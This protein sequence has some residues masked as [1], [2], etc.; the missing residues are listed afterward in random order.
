MSEKLRFS[1]LMFL[2]F[3]GALLMVGGGCGSGKDKATGTETKGKIMFG[4]LGW[5]SALV[6]NEIARFIIENGYGYE[7]DSMP[8]ETIPLFMGLARGDIDVDMEVWTQNQQEAYDK[9]VADGDVIDLG[10]N[11]N[12]NFQG[13]FVPT[14]VIKGDPER[15]IE[16]LA[17][18]LRTIDDLP[19]YWEIFKD[20]EDPRKGRFY[21][22]VPGWEADK[23][24]TEQFKTYGLDQYYNI[25]RPGSGTALATSLVGAYEKGKPWFGYYWGPT[26]IMGKL[27]LTQIEEPPYNKEAWEKDFGCSF[28]AVDVNICV[29]KNLP[30]RAPEVVEFLRKYTTNSA[31]VSEVLAYMQEEDATEKD[32]AL[33][34]LREKQNVWLQWVPDDVA[35]KVKTKL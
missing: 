3:L 17:P 27:D 23:I 22:G 4:D 16:P 32:A 20:P 29:N 18:D 25:F 5:E 33:W 2:L 13:M 7:T 14:Y 12:D 34:F 15:G 21:G 24:L 30:E 28:P 19:K 6:N 10:T 9:A 26:W 35:E 8:G 31:L 1:V 11:F